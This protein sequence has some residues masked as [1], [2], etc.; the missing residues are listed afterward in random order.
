MPSAAVSST[1]AS[2]ASEIVGAVR[3]FVD[4]LPLG[5]A[6]VRSKGFIDMKVGPCDGARPS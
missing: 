5:G 4:P 2:W 3:W 6:S 1:L